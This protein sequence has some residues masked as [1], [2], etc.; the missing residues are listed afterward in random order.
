MACSMSPTVCDFSKLVERGLVHRLEAE[1]DE[2]AVRGP[3]ELHEFLVAHDVGAHLGAPR[4]GDALVDHELEEPLEAF[5]VGRHVVVV[6]EDLLRLL[7]LDLLHHALG[8]AEAVLLA[9]HRRHRAERAVEGAAP[10]GHDGRVAD[11]FVAVHEREVRERQRVEVLAALVQGRVHGHAVLAP[12]RDAGDGAELAVAGQRLRELHHDRLSGFAARHIVRMLQG[13]V[14][15]E[16]DVRTADDDGDAA[17]AQFIADAVRLD[18]G[19]GGAGDADEVGGVDVGP[20]DRRELRIEDPHVVTGLDQ[21][22]ADHG[23][24]KPHEVRLGPE[25]AAWR[26]WF[27]QAD[28][29]VKRFLTRGWPIRGCY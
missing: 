2:V 7:L 27:D 21:R 11:P 1:G 28:L 14:S 25:M 19:G 15:H 6:E 8:A 17:A 12:V 5:P 26:D 20:V 23:K 24:T 18:D 16:R 29:H 10:A 9:E 3:H 13:L 4:H 22:G